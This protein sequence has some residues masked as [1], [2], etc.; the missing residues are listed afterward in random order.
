L[1]A[2]R[3]ALEETLLECTTFLNAPGRPGVR[4][5][6]VDREGFP[7]FDMDALLPIREARRKHAETTTDLARIM[8]EIQQALEDLHQNL[9]G[10]WQKQQAPFRVRATRVPTTPTYDA[11]TETEHTGSD[12]D[13][14]SHVAAATHTTMPKAVGFCRVNEVR[15]GSPAAEAGLRV[16][17][18]IAEFAHLKHSN[19]NQLQELPGVVQSAFTANAAVSVLVIRDDQQVA[20]SLRPRRWAGAG[21]LGYVAPTNTSAST[22]TTSAA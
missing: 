19:H 18:V 12:R 14:D 10:M 5:S 6:L 1:I 11:Q 17:D 4:G 2:R 20:L 15:A 22:T 9:R 8:H 13:S 16:N 3:T 21:V 7:M